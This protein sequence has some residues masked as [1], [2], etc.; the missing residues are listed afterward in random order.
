[1]QPGTGTRPPPEPGDGGSGRSAESRRGERRRRRGKGG[2]GAGGRCR[3][4]TSLLC[5]RGSAGAGTA[6]AAGG[7]RG[8]RGPA[9]LTAP[10]P[11]PPSPGRPPA[12]RSREDVGEAVLFAAL[13]PGA[14]RAGPGVRG[15][16]VVRERL[17][18]HAAGGPGGAELQEAADHPG[19]PRAGVLGAAREEGCAGAGG[20]VRYAELPRDPGGRTE[21]GARPPPRGL[22]PPLDG[23]AG[24]ASL[25]RAGLRRAGSP[26]EGGPW[27]EPGDLGG[28]R[29][30]PGGV[31]S[32]SGLRRVKGLRWTGHQQ[33]PFPS[34]P[35]P[36][37]PCP[38]SSAAGGRVSAGGTDGTECRLP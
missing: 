13:L 27:R 16:G 12:R 22:R 34:E 3:L 32:P 17:P 36:S 26:Q 6:T 30:K 4:L 23:D 31:V 9:P 7:R 21:V 10:A 19:V 38:G 20:E 18:R 8:G 29:S 24:A 1:M 15:R 37:L 25:R 5:L 11:L 35:G 33:R 2:K 14:L 28:C